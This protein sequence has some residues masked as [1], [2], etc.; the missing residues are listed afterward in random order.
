MGSK[1]NARKQRI[2]EGLVFKHDDN[3]ASNANLYFTKKL[4]GKQVE[5]ISQ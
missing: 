1:T 4:I 3:I 2:V 5:F